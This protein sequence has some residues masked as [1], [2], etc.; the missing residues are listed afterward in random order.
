MRIIPGTTVGERGI[1]YANYIKPPRL[2]TSDRLFSVLRFGRSSTSLK[3]SFM[4]FIMFGIANGCLDLGYLNSADDSLARS[5]RT[6]TLAGGGEPVTADV[7]ALAGTPRHGT[8]DTSLEGWERDLFSSLSLSPLIEPGRCGL[9][10]ALGAAAFHLLPEMHS[11]IRRSRCCSR[12]GR[13]NLS[14]TRFLGSEFLSI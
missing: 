10:G 7:L 11:E 6:E 4:S 12:P 14:E 8:F 5:P 9:G 13:Q 3:S 2:L 1:L